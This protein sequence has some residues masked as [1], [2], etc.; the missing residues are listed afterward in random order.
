MSLTGQALLRSSQAMRC[1]DVGNTRGGAIDLESAD[2]LA[3]P[4]H[5]T[6]K[7]PFRSCYEHLAIAEHDSRGEL[8]GSGY[9]CNRRLS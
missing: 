8:V 6:A 3:L 9:S 4:I 2:V 7:L 1:P 5:G